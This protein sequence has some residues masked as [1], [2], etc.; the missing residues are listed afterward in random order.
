MYKL[1][2]I[3]ILDD[4]WKP[5]APD[6]PDYLLWLGAGNTP[7]QDGFPSL[8]DEKIRAIHYVRQQ[9]QQAENAID[10]LLAGNFV[11]AMMLNSEIVQYLTAGRPAS[12]S[13]SVY[14]L[15]KAL[16][17]RRGVALRAA[18][19]TLADRWLTLRSRIATII[20]E[21]DRLEDEIDAAT[22]VA[23]IATVLAGMDWA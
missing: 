17:D 1:T 11:R 9:A 10:A 13:A 19:E 7:E 3:G 5:V 20:V 18:L 2:P 23:E 21:L 16:A 22:T 15:A 12:P 6:D 14:V 8:A 4:N